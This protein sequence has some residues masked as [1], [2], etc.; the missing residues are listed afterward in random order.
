MTPKAVAGSVPG[1]LARLSV[2]DA[3]WL[4]R[5]DV[6]QLPR[7]HKMITEP[8]AGS[9]AVARRVAVI[10][11]G[12]A[13]IKDPTLL[14]L[15]LVRE[16]GL[17]EALQSDLSPLRIGYAIRYLELTVSG[18]EAWL[19]DAPPQVAPGHPGDAVPDAWGSLTHR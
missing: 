6:G 14:A 10:R 4:I 7:V 13:P 1:N 3:W 5:H 12:L 9:H 15:S 2:D 19:A 11:R 17:A 8:H 16:A 18:Q